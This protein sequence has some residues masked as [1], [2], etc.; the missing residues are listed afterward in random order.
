MDFPKLKLKNIIFTI[1]HQTTK[2]VL[3]P[4]TPGATT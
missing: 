2:A 4:L 1:E 3:R